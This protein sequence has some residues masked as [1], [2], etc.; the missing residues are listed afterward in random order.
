MTNHSRFRTSIRRF[1]ALL[2]GASAAAIAGAVAPAAAQSD[3]D[4]GLQEITVTAQRRVENQQDVP[5]SVATLSDERL[6][7][8][9]S[10]GDD[11]LA[12]AATVP[13]LYAES[14]NGRL[15]PRFYIRGLGNV[16]FDVA[17]SQP[18]SI[19]MD[20]VVLENVVLKSSPIFD[21][22]QVEVLRGPQGTLF[23]RNTPAG[24]VKFT[25]KKP[26]QE[27]DAFASVSYGTYNTVN[28]EAAIGGPLIKD[29]LSVRLS[30]LLQRRSDW[31]DNDFLLQKDALGGYRE[32]AGRAQLLFTPTENFSALINFHGRDNEGTSALFRAN[33]LEKGTGNLVFPNYNRDTVYFDG[34]AGNPQQANGWGLNGKLDY[35]FGGVTLTSITAF[36]TASSSSRG[37][38]DGG[39][40]GPQSFFNP[41][42]P[43][44]PP[45]TPSRIRF[46]SDTQDSVDDLDQFTQEIRLASDGSGRF[47]WQI[48][49]YYF[50]SDLTVSTVGPGFPPLTTLKHD[51]DSWAV[52]GQGSY[53][54]TDQW[55]LTAGLRY[56]EDDRDFR[57]LVL[58]PGVTVTPSS[59]NA[60]DLSWDVSLLY[61]ASDAVNLYA[62]VA[63]GFRGP[64][65][66][67]RDVAFAAFSGAVNPQTIAKEE[68]ILSYEAGFKSQFLDDRARLNFTA[69]YYTVDDQQFSII[70]GAGNVNQVINA[71]KGV[72]WGFEADAQFLI[73]EN[74]FV[75]GGFS[76]NNTE[77]Q[78]AALATAPCGSG[79]CTVLDP[80][81]GFGQARID[82]NPFPNAPEL[83]FNIFAEYKFPL[84]EKGELFVNT[85]WD[86]QGK[87]NLFL[88]ESAEFR[89]S[90]NFE[91]GVRA[92]YR[93]A[94]GRLE[95]A[96]FA[97]NVTD[98]SNVAGGIDFNNLTAFVNEPRI[99]GF[100]LTLRR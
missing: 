36:E 1:S 61:K 88:Y 94:D 19:I 48:G 39:F 4:P 67:G 40:V 25:T 98:E 80:L 7:Q 26:T 100:Q 14:S 62:R 78:D 64:T 82:G 93:S 55:R 56:T 73:S 85:D 12:L 95:G 22:E 69:Y 57:A 33:I 23:G 49:G 68:T 54:L 63:R 15:A 43:P 92:G 28:A 87:T 70:G 44:A 46:P 52:F 66:Q 29:V 20:E 42:L 18:V 99:V 72:G 91:G 81:N 86:V 35:D 13:S 10:S 83:T 50:T 84:G 24:I 9:K 74:F 17:A 34:G 32:F 90:G 45:F 30:G 6:Q 2:C 8:I 96:F 59:A 58:P 5:L 11:I 97:R 37:D 60:D 21:I 77:I 89:T 27:F 51:N 75:S 38:I 53:D 47:N 3:E 41:A 79:L 16:D 76:Y 71:D 31:V 65:I